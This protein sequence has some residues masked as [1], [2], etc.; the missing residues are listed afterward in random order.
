MPQQQSHS[1]DLAILLV[2]IVLC[3]G[4]MFVAFQPRDNSSAA[5][6]PASPEIDT[7][8][9]NTLRRLPRTARVATELL[10]Q[11]D[12]DRATLRS[13]LIRMATFKQTEPETLLWELI[14]GLTAD[15]SAAL[16]RN[17]VR[18]VADF[19]DR[20]TSEQRGQLKQLTGSANSP[21]TQQVAFAAWIG[22]DKNIGAAFEH[23]R[24]NEQQL[25]EFLTALPMVESESVRRQASNSIRTLWQA[26]SETSIRIQEQAVQTMVQLPGSATEKSSELIALLEA[27]RLRSAAIQALTD[28]PSASWSAR[29]LGKLAAGLIAWIAE[30]PADDRHSTSMAAAWELCEQL[31]PMLPE[32]KRERFQQRVDQLR[33][34]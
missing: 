22:L 25:T 33:V 12:I 13:A 27:R 4:V 5:A 7:S 19:P 3:G 6:P 31:V 23:A 24:S 34:R 11:P 1:F 32:A 28:L 18:L 10:Q 9:S 20:S 15:S 26:D 30:H 21:A 14:A 29:D 8:D 16:R 2:T 17:L